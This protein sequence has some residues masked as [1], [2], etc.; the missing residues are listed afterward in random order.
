MTP[1]NDLTNRVQRLEVD[2]IDLK[3]AV[4]ALIETVDLHQ[5]NFEAS[6]RNFDAIVAEIR[7]IRTDTRGL[8]T[9]NR[10]LLNHL[11]GEADSDLD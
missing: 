3:L 7:D 2:N 6:Q 5:R 1:A 11:L 4:S 10:R 9:E 8:Q